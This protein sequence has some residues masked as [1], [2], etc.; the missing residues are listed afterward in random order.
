M[1]TTDATATEQAAI[2]QAIQLYIDGV[3]KGDA[4]KLKETFHEEAWMLGSIGGQ[5]FDIPSP[6]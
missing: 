4:A 5:R 3:S 1:A 6:R 2:E